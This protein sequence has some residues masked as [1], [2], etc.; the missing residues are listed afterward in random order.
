M[1]FATWVLVVITSVY[2]ALTGALVWIGRSQLSRESD[3]VAYG[4]VSQVVIGSDAKGTYLQW[5]PL[6][7]VLRDS[8][9]I[10]VVLSGHLTLVE[11]N[12][13]PARDLPFRWG[14]IPVLEPGDAP[15]N[16]VSHRVPELGV[17]GVDDVAIIV[18]IA[19]GVEYSDTS[20]RRHVS[21]F[22]SSPLTVRTLS[23]GTATVVRVEGGVFYSQSHLRTR[24]N[25]LRG[26]LRHSLGSRIETRRRDSRLPERAG[27]ESPCARPAYPARPVSARNPGIGAFY[28]RRVP[29]QGVMGFPMIRAW[30]WLR[31]VA[32]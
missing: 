28:I 6:L 7:S 20:R 5:A 19:V 9:A 21:L 22:T 29:A 13:R 11:G 14:T 27:V 8:P 24:F 31:A 32:R 15:Q 12:G 16:S 10:N 23:G 18:F 1:E 2:V 17:T 3:P 30:P 25:K 26:R 4:R